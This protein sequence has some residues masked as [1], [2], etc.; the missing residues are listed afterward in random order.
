[1]MQ[2]LIDSQI[3][4]TATGNSNAMIQASLTQ[5]PRWG[6]KR[7]SIYDNTNGSIGPLIIIPTLFGF[8]RLIYG[9]L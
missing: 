8:L 6:H 5:K 2:N 3:L 9:M 7:S 4:A 1:M